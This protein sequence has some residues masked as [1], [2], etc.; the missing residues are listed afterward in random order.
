MNIQIK[1][2]IIIVSIIAIA[3]I[4]IFS[5]FLIKNN[6]NFI[7]QPYS[8]EKTQIISREFDQSWDMNHIMQYDCALIKANDAKNYC[9]TKQQTLTDFYTGLTWDF[10]EP[11]LTQKQLEWFYCEML[12]EP[13]IKKCC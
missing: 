8:E 7:E 12:S 13:E 5:I 9:E 3:L 6:F 2:N 11:Q 4:V 10:I 1:R